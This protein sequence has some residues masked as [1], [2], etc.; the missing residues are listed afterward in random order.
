LESS[1]RV[2]KILGLILYYG[3]TSHLPRTSLGFIGKVSKKIRALSVELFFD[4][5][6]KNVNVDRNC[7]VGKGR[8]EIGDNSGIGRDS[9]VYGKLVIGCNVLVAPEVVFYTRNH[10]TK[11]RALPIIKQGY[12]EESP[13]VIGDDVWIG[14]RAMIMPGV[15]IGNGSVIAA[16]SVVTKSIQAFTI[17]GGVPAKE[18]GKRN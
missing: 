6:G 4:K 2:K 3:F 8:I 18:I 10:K 17:V 11:L 16:G 14:R 1:A 9:E 7:Y 5:V 12:T 15:N 13:I